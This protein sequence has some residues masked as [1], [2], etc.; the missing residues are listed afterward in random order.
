MKHTGVQE[1][2]KVM[3]KKPATSVEQMLESLS[4][5]QCADLNTCTECQ[6]SPVADGEDYCRDCVAAADLANSSVECFICKDEFRHG[7]THCGRCNVDLVENLSEVKTNGDGHPA[8]APAF[9]V[10]MGDYCGFFSLDEAR[11][12]R[13]QLRGQRIRSEIVVRESPDVDWDTPIREEF[14]LRVESGRLREASASL[15]Q[16][17]PT[18][19]PEQAGD[20]GSFACSDCGQVIATEEIFCPK[21]GA[22]FED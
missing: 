4:N 5:N 2:N 22:R 15:E 9:P 14:W 3:K 13:D 8:P 7:F 6:E 21:C 18:A 10:R 11:Q 19:E 20:S 12:A 17:T 16:D 1:G